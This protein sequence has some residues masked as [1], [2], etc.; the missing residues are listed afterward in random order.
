MGD[1]LKPG[2]VQ[3]HLSGGIQYT[4]LITDK[5]N[6]FISTVITCE[7][8][9]TIIGF[10]GNNMDLPRAVGIPLQER[11][12]DLEFVLQEPTLFGGDMR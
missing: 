4:W 2:G 6:Q 1:K 11:L 8:V 10:T 7:H 3:Q 5:E 9:T 12:I